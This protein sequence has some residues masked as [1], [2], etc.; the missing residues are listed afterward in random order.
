MNYFKT[1]NVQNVSKMTKDKNIFILYE[2]LFIY[3]II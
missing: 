1:I 2:K 3:I